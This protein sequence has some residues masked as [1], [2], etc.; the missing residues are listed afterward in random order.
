MMKRFDGAY[1]VDCVINFWN[2]ARW[3]ERD[4]EELFYQMFPNDD[5]EEC[6]GRYIF[7]DCL[8]RMTT[9]SDEDR[10]LWEDVHFHITE[11]GYR[12]YNEV[13]MIF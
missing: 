8:E 6:A 3:M 12:F 10:E 1:E 9:G 5:Y 7:I 2:L 11:A 13:L 4:A